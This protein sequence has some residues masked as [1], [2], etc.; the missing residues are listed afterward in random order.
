[1]SNSFLGQPD[2]P[3][4][5]AGVPVED[6]LA[7]AAPSVA[8]ALAQKPVDEEGV[9]WDALKHLGQVFTTAR[10]SDEVNSG[11]LANGIAAQEAAEQRNA[12]IQA[13]TGVQLDNPYR[14]APITGT[15]LDDPSASPIDKMALQSYA[16]AH[17]EYH[18]GEIPP[19]GDQAELDGYRANAWRGQLAGLATEHPDQASIIGADQPI[20]PDANAL[21]NS[22]AAAAS[23]TYGAGGAA[24]WLASFA[25]GAAA[26]RRDPIQ[27]AGLFA[28]PVEGAALKVTDLLGSGLFGRMMAKGVGQGLT[29]AALQTAEEPTTQAW[30]ASLGQESGIVPALKDIGFAGL[31]GFVPGAAHEGAASLIKA[32]IGGSRQAAAELAQKIPASVAPELHA[33][34]ASDAADRAAPEPP[35]TVKP[36]DAVQVYREAV[37]FGEDPTNNPLPEP[38]P[39]IRP[40]VDDKAAIKAL[41]ADRDLS[42][43]Q[44]QPDLFGQVDDLENRISGARSAVAQRQAEAA[45]APP[46]V[47]DERIADLQSQLDA[48]TGKRKSSPAAKGLRDQIAGLQEG[49]AAQGEGEGAKAKNAEIAARL[50][51]ADLQQRRA[52]LGP[53]VRQANADFNA[54]DPFRTV[55]VLRRDPALI[56]SALSS[57]RPDVKMAGQLAS[58][59]DDAMQRV[60]NGEVDPAYAAHV[61]AMVADPLDHGSYLDELAHFRPA[62]D[63]AARQVISDAMRERA[64]PQAVQAMLGGDPGPVITL[65]SAR[66]GLVEALRARAAQADQPREV[67]V[68]IPRETPA[69]RAAHRAELEAGLKGEASGTEG[70]EKSP[71]DPDAKKTAPEK[72]GAPLKKPDRLLDAIPTGFAEDGGDYR[73]V[74]REELIADK[75]RAEQLA[76][77]MRNCPL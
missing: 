37:R 30:R 19:G 72:I 16:A 6:A 54:G 47:L 65:D 60:R 70:A 28:G 23:Q 43:R 2:L 55:D 44:A 36:A 10:K 40:G 24:A 32:A 3:P 48:F 8:Q 46:P 4:I 59:S 53:R 15:E 33:A 51:L 76:N 21:A 12:Q 50:N 62:N 49:A 1:M 58:L 61:G 41:A 13:A 22:R 7:G 68:T 64:F 5:G 35:A 38:A 66:G 18:P 14:R 42:L 45:A 73:P 52:A 9:D 74:S 20:E 71:Q 39:A 56:E 27:M 77:L 29:N 75:P 57:E 25:G 67:P 31:F 11:I 63:A 26:M 17:P 34:I 69:E